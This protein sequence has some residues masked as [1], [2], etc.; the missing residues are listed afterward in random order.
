MPDEF[1]TCETRNE[2]GGG[3]RRNAV[4]REWTSILAQVR[5]AL[6][7]VPSRVAQRLPRVTA[8][9]VS[10]IDAEIRAVLAE[11]ETS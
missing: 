1:Q 8:H 5:A 4:E 7:A 3:H 2:S 6:L 11:I 9:D 10:E